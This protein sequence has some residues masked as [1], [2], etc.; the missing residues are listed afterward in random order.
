MRELDQIEV[1]KMFP[2]QHLINPLLIAMLLMILPNI[3]FSTILRRQ[4]KRQ[5]ALVGDTSE[6]LRQTAVAG[7]FQAFCLGVGL[8][9]CA[10][11]L[12]LILENHNATMKFL[13]H[14]PANAN[15]VN[16]GHPKDR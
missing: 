6:N 3:A 7:W 4:T 10:V 11:S 1:A 16:L 9:L 14:S 5:K 12:F 13:T 15:Y 8:T 2:Y